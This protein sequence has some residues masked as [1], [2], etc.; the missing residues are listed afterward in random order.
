[1]LATEVA[2]DGSLR[3][4]RNRGDFDVLFFKANGPLIAKR[5]VSGKNE[6]AYFLRVCRVKLARTV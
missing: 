1:M 3:V 2:V 6:L 4:L 5:T